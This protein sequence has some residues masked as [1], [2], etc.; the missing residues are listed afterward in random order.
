[1]RNGFNSGYQANPEL[2]QDIF[3]QSE[4]HLSLDLISVVEQVAATAIRTNDWITVIGGNR[5][6]IAALVQAGVSRGR[7]RWVVGRDADQR[8][9]A[10]EQALLAGTSSVV[11]SWLEHLTP[12]AQQRL[13]M[14]SKVSATQSY[15]F[16][17]I[18]SLA[19][20]H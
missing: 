9:W 12:R 10:T 20:L 18:P 13:K 8:E 7:I 5:D 17:D 11:L 1:M 2:N 14:A 16:N 15:I 19:P 6:V 3:F 4:E